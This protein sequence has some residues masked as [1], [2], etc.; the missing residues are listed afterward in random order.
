MNTFDLAILKTKQLIK[1]RVLYGFLTMTDFNEIILSNFTL[2]EDEIK[3]LLT[4]IDEAGIG[5]IDEMGKPMLFEHDDVESELIDFSKAQWEDVNAVEVSDGMRMYLQEIGRIPLLTAEQE[6][7]LAKRIEEGDSDA[8]AFL[9]EANLRLVVSISKKYLGRGLQFL[10]LIQEGNIGLMKAVDKFDYKLGFKFST[11]A[12]WWIR[13]SI[14]RAIA[15]QS[16]TIRIPVHMG[17]LKYKVLKTSQ[18]IENEHG[19]EASPKEIAQK[20]DWPIEKVLEVMSVVNDPV[21]LD[22]A[23][24]ST[25]DSRLSD[26]IKD[27]SVQN[28]ADIVTKS[29]LSHCLNDVMDEVLTPREKQVLMYRMGYQ[30]GDKKTLEEIGKEFDLTRERIR[31]IEKTAIRK[32]RQTKNTI[33]LREFYEDNP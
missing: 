10:D 22:T 3:E 1:S 4:M 17:E 14:Q 16:R 11:Y 23:I 32:L 21:S 5:I 25:D 13:Q 8:K 19:R 28:P 9:A 15:D 29:V 7:A 20:L 6:I 24:R 18:Q 30:N 12:T 31:Q 2:Q 33:E 26:F 27:D